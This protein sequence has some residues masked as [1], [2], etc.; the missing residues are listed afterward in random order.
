MAQ[1]AK[2]VTEDCLVF[3]D[4]RRKAVVNVIPL[5]NLGFLPRTGEL[6]YLPGAHGDSG[7]YR[8]EAIE[9]RNHTERGDVALLNIT[10]SVIAIP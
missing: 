2:G 6:L 8:V 3:Y 1:T 5:T 4:L 10:A 9:H 7:Q